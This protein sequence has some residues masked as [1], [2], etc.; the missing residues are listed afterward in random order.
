MICLLSMI[1]GIVSALFISVLP[2]EKTY[3]TKK[4]I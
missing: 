1:S 4:K 3:P 2:K